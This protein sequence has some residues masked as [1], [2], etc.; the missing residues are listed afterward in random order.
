MYIQTYINLTSVPMPSD[1]AVEAHSQHIDTPLRLRLAFF[2]GGGVFV[3]FVFLWGRRDFFAYS[4][5]VKNAQKNHMRHTNINQDHILDTA[6]IHHIRKPKHITQNPTNMITNISVSVVQN[7]D[8]HVSPLRCC[9]GCD[10]RSAGQFVAMIGP[11]TLI[12]KLLPNGG[13]SLRPWVTTVIR[14]L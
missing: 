14:Y 8:S 11:V 4:E 2:L 1:I 7:Q 13:I 9:L 12:R 6:S 3:V 10:C 5:T